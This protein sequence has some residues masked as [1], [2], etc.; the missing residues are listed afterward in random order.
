MLQD[1]DVV[2]NGAIAVDEE[3]SAFRSMQN[4]SESDQIRRHAKLGNRLLPH[5]SYRSRSRQMAGC[6]PQ[7]VSMVLNGKQQ[8]NMIDS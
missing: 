1:T 3:S 7:M 8:V 4:E 2:G 5:G 6:I